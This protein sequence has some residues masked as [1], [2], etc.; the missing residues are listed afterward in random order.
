METT[1]PFDLKLAIQRWRENLGQSPDFRSENLAE[2]ESHLRDSTLALK[3]CGL[4][5]EEAFVIAVKRIGRSNSLAAEFAKINGP[6][7]WLERILWMLIGA[8]VCMIVAAFYSVFRTCAMG[9]ASRMV[10]WIPGMNEP[11]Y[12]TIIIFSPPALV[13]V[14][15]MA[16][17][18]RLRRFR[19]ETWNPFGKLLNNPLT[20]ALSL[21]LLC[22]GFK[23]FASGIN[24]YVIQPTLFNTAVTHWKFVIANSVNELPEYVV[25]AA[26]VYF[27]ARKRL[28][29]SKA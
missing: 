23:L 21:F 18:R 2:L 10:E 8:Q 29:L 19:G 11:A 9:F 15:V 12:W 28:R 3:K 26:L 16:V 17:W 27:F 14:T 25:C 4:S 5:D 7:I 24:T 13:A 6:T 22:F 20:L 1:T